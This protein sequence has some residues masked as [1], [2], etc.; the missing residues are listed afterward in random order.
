MQQK[1][2]TPIIILTITST[3]LLVYVGWYLY[4]YSFDWSVLYMGVLVTFQT[5]L[6][7]S[8][9][10]KYIKLRASDSFLEANIY[11]YATYPTI[12]F[13]KKNRN[14]FF[15]N[16]AAIVL[17]GNMQYGSLTNLLGIENREFDLFI[18]SVI[19]KRTG[20]Q[21]FVMKK[22]NGEAQTSIIDGYISKI[23]NQTYITIVIQPSR[24]SKLDLETVKYKKT[25]EAI[26]NLS[27]DIIFRQDVTNRTWDYLSPGVELVTGHSMEFFKFGGV[28]VFL[29]LIH[30]DDLDRVGLY[31]ESIFNASHQ[32]NQQGKIAYR[33]KH[34][35]GSYR[36]LN[37]QHTFQ[38]NEKGK[39][40]Y[41]TGAASDITYIREQA[42]AEKNNKLHY[43]EVFN[44]PSDVIFIHDFET[45]EILEVNN[46]I[47]TVYGYK[48]EE[49][50]G[51]CIEDLSAGIDGY[52]AKNANKWINKAQTDGAQLFEWRAKRKDGKLFWV[53]I[54]L[55][56]SSI[57]NKK[58]IIAVVRDVSRK[59]KTQ[60]D[61]LLTNQKYRTYINSV[62]IA[63][64]EIDSSNVILEVNSAACS[65]LAQ[66]EPDLIGV[67][68]IEIFRPTN[69][70]SE[71]NW[72]NEGQLNEYIYTGEDNTQK[73]F[74]ISS[75]RIEDHGKIVFCNDI[76]DRKRF[77]IS[78]KNIDNAFRNEPSSSYMQGI[79]KQLS[80]S[81][82]NAEFVFMG[83]LESGSKELISTEYIYN[84]GSLIA[85]FDFSINGSVSEAVVKEGVQSITENIQQ[86]FP[87]DRLLADMDIESYIGVPLLNKEQ[88]VIGVL[89]AL[90]LS[91]L[92]NEQLDK[93][94]IQF[95]AQRISVELER[96]ANDN[97]I[98]ALNKTL[99]V[100]VGIRTEE[101]EAINS[102]LE[103]FA[104][105]VSH[106]LKSPLRGIAQLA[107]WIATDYRDKIDEK[108]KGILT[109]LTGRVRKMNNLIDGILLFSRIGRVMESTEK[110]DM[111]TLLS[112]VVEM[113]AVSANISVRLPESLP[114][115][116]TEKIRIQQI[117][118][119]LIGN[120]IKYMDKEDG[121]VEV[122]MQEN[123][124]EFVFTVK[125]NGPGI[126]PKYHE[127]V[128]DIFQTL[129]SSDDTDSTGVGLTIV[130]K[131]VDHHGGKVW[132]ESH[133]E[134]CSFIF[135]LKKDK[136]LRHENN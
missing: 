110:I 86:V 125:D 133:D 9:K 95:F 4:A 98:K 97:N 68:I 10:K 30:P 43:L 90:F 61:F 64:V 34:A 59:K 94:I 129:G 20:N 99:E 11:K 130:K 117:F 25:I 41:V 91:P 85:N 71:I 49:V 22:K 135:S 8:L 35:N 44:A 13:N 3:M 50:T 119:N 73:Y 131:I 89:S 77:E 127:K 122:T 38:V 103:N 58:R 102:E 83:K 116:Y 5:T 55:S 105:I 92:K 23:S 121:I 81:L 21:I 96:E 46:A 15:F 51:I 33:I 109:L 39:A 132:I 114:V 62:P 56:F 108:G 88:E 75:V 84:K 1:E 60:R 45:G 112:D 104:Y 32:N 111:I 7:F 93:S 53:E 82:Q 67:N 80:N 40:I 47:E 63:I 24:L 70:D 78:I 66:K 12:T 36:W 16:D 128:F 52:N 37:D 101:L 57:N 26:F 27:P 6:L 17:F 76:T 72:A 31:F 123:E 65:L 113:L 69:S 28:E 100:K 14:R 48:R 42:F 74:T 18:T 29:N 120:S 2:R 118:Q 106:D 79:I 115:F 107:S 136:V 134:G 87:K 19:T 126:S 54:T 124:N